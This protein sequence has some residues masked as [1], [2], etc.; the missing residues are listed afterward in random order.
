MSNQLM[1][2]SVNLIIMKEYKVAL[3]RTYIVTIEAES[4]EKAK[5][6]SEFFLGDCPDKSLKKERIEKS[7]EIKDVELV[8]NDASK[9]LE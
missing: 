2:N 1:H 7:F 8:F 6:Y 3:T 5:R 4:L 9:L